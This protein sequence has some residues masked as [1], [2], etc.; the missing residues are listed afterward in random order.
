MSNTNQTKAGASVA[1]RAL[2]DPMKLA[3]QARFQETIAAAQARHIAAAAEE[4]AN[5]AAV[6]AQ[7]TPAALADARG[8]GFNLD[9]A[10]Q[11]RLD[12]AMAIEPTIDAR[13]T[14]S[15]A[16][17]AALAAKAT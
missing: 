17:F 1:T 12:H 3:R 14:A 8:A 9:Q 10:L 4:K 16:G 13:L 11:A 5:V 6:K 7:V 15:L 2:L